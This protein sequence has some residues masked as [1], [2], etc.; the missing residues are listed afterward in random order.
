MTVERNNIR[1]IS[2]HICYDY[3]QCVAGEKDKPDERFVRLV[4][5]MES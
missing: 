4:F 5:V 2:K 1:N 3:G